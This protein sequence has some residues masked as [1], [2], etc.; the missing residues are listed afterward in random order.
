[1][2]RSSLSAKRMDSPSM[3]RSRGWM[4]V[5]NEVVTMSPSLLVVARRRLTR[6]AEELLD[7]ASKLGVMLKQKPV[8]RVR[9]DFHPS[10][11]NQAREQI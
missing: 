8:G 4:D 7:I 9:I 5:F 2:F 10:L 11:R 3:V 6:V 1:M